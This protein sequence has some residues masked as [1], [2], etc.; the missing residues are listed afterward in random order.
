MMHKI[1]GLALV[2]LLAGCGERSSPSTTAPP[3][4]EKAAIAALSQI[5]Q[6]QKDFIRRNRRYALGYEDLISDHLL[7]A[8]PTAQGYRIEMKPSPDAS[9]YTISATPTNASATARHL[10]TDE[11]GV[12]RVEQSKD[13]TATS[14]AI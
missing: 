11:T 2:I 3:P 14:P 8:E 5:N 4:D 12:I 9:R 6:A 1:L 10:F 13:A 7:Q